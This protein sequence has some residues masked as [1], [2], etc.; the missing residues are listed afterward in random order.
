MPTTVKHLRLLSRYTRMSAVALAQYPFE[1]AMKTVDL[2][3]T[4]LFL[5]TFWYSVTTFGIVI[6]GWSQSEILVMTG[7]GLLGSAITQMGFGFRD[8]SGIVLDGTLDLYLV[9]PVHPLFTILGERLFV[10]WVITQ[11]ASGYALIRLGAKTGALSLVNWLPALLVLSL[12]CV[13]FQAIYGCLSLT[14]FWLGR[15]SSLRDLFFSLT[16]IKKYPTDVLPNALSRAITW[17]LPIGLLA[18]VPAQIVLGKVGEP[19]TSVLWVAGLALC[20][21]VALMLLWR[22]ALVGYE[23]TGS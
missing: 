1:L 22:K 9:R 20:W 16:M 8:I 23:S 4:V 11:S 14:S 21:T 2:G 19:W 17:V 3:F 5:Y 6:P 10:F 12:G 7:M 18:T 15:V 13:A